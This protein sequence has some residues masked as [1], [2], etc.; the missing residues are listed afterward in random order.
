MTKR[1]T[2]VACLLLGAGLL[3]AAGCASHHWH[4]HA[5]ACCC[6]P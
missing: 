2:L 5:R 4:S 1:F 3:L 6:A